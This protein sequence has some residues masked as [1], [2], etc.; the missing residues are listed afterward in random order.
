MIVA[1]RAQTLSPACALLG[2]SSTHLSHEQLVGNE[3]LFGAVEDGQ[4]DEESAPVSLALRK[5]GDL[6]VVRV[7]DA[8]RDYK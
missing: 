1:A 4:C 6:A 7:H 8:L 2:L 3:V 5:H